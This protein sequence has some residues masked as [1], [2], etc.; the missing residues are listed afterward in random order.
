MPWGAL[1]DG[2]EE[3]SDVLLLFEVNALDLRLLDGPPGAAEADV[4]PKKGP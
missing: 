4:A 1:E 3:N 2:M